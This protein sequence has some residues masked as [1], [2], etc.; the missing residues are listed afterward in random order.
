MLDMMAAAQPRD[1]M[2]PSRAVT[3]HAFAPT[4]PPAR[5]TPAGRNN[6][7]VAPPPLPPRSLRRPLSPRGSASAK[8]RLWDTEL[9][10]GGEEDA[11][12]AS[13]AAGDAD[14]TPLL[15]SLDSVW[16]AGAPQ[17]HRADVLDLCRP[18]TAPSDPKARWMQALAR[19]R[20][21]PNADADMQN[22]NDSDRVVPRD[23]GHDV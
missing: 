3:S 20:G 23:R 10:L 4:T 9:P 21:T 15:P 17:R 8:R 12:D 7:D 16:A 13:G 18:E 22:D 11:L 5:T 19:R 6:T 2:L 14:L 1:G